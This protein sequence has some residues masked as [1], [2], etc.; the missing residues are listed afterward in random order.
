MILLDTHVWIWWITDRARLSHNALQALSTINERNPALIS[1][2]SSWELHLLVTKKRLGLATDVTH[3]IRKCEESP[4]IRFLPVDNEIVR[5]ASQ[6]PT[7][8]PDDPADRL[9]IASA[10]SSSATLVTKD[11][12]IRKSGAVRTLW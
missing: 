1:S 12:K 6:L 5:I 3:W 7:N 2:I 10:L 8:V 9:I 11:E 4:E